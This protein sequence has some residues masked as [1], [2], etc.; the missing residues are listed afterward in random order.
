[1]PVREFCQWIQETGLS[2]ALAESV[3]AYPII[4]AVH[5]L[6]IALFGGAVLVAN[7]RTLGFIRVSEGLRQWKWVGLL[8]MA[9]TG[10]LLFACGP[11]RY[12]DS[13]FFRVKLLLLVGVA[14]NAWFA[15]SRRLGA[16]LSLAFWVGIIFASRGIAF[17]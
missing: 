6:G 4:G 15:G 14:A 13:V 9:S 5:V 2:R 7:L 12:Y 3:W 8:G 17:F 16:W 10:V 1:M 11:V